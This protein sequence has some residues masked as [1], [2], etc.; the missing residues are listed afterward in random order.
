MENLA[1]LILPTL[2]VILYVWTKKDIAEYAAFKKLSSTEARQRSYRTWLAKSFL[3]FGCGAPLLLVLL[4]HW[5]DITAPLQ[6]LYAVLPADFH[7]KLQINASYASSI[8]G[9]LFGA[10][11]I[12]IVIG[13]LARKKTAT[14]K[15]AAQHIAMGD[16]EALL[17]RNNAERAWASLLA[18]NAGFSEELFF[19]VLLPVVFYLVFHNAYVAIGA[20]I[21]VFGCIHYY[22]GYKGVLATTFMGGLLMFVY[23]STGSIWIA[24][25]LHAFIDIN[26][27]IFQPLLLRTFQRTS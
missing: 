14:N 20:S 3:F 26:S 22:Q 2:L 16:V 19:R 13:V 7:S 9:M 4:G 24:M 6:P 25:L 8:L 27:L 17:P 1:Y 21:I 23:F 15:K 18:I 5:H 12:G 10:L 11:A